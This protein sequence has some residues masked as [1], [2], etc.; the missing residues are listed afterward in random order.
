MLGPQGS[1]NAAQEAPKNGKI[2]TKA[3][4]ELP[5]CSPEEGQHYKNETKRPPELPKWT[6]WHPWAIG[7]KILQTKRQKW[8]PNGAHVV[9]KD[10]RRL[11]SEMWE[12]RCPPARSLSSIAIVSPWRIA[13]SFSHGFKKTQTV[14]AQDTN[15]QKERRSNQ[16]KKDLCC[17]QD[18]ATTHQ[19]WMG[20]WKMWNAKIAIFRYSN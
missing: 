3:S 2:E 8:T 16:A 13:I 5:K 10:R 15:D 19:F 6:L 4:P 12:T 14:S 20:V 1:Q 18:A 7:L 17:V 9:P 11:G